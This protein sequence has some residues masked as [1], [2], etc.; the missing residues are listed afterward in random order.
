M[1]SETKLI[2][3]WLDSSRKNRAQINKIKNERSGGWVGGSR[4]RDVHIVMTDLHC[5]MTETNTTL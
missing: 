5:C 3:L 2:N 1:K 4:R